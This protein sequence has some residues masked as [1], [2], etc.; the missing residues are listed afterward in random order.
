MPIKKNK[1]KTVEPFNI[2]Y[3][4]DCFIN[5]LLC[6]AKYYLLDFLILA[7][8]CYAFYDI[9]GNQLVSKKVKVFSIEELSNIIGLK[10]CR[11]RDYLIQWKQEYKSDFECGNLIIAP[12][13]DYY[14]PLRIDAYNKIHA[15][16]YTLLYDMNDKDSTLSVI[17]SKYRM[18]VFYKNMKMRYEDYEKSHFQKGM[19]YRYV[20]SKDMHNLKVQYKEKYKER[21]LHIIQFLT[22]QSISNLDYYICN[23]CQNASI[24][25]A[26]WI[27]NLNNICNQSKV[28][29]YIFDNIIGNESL[30]TISIEIL[31][32]WYLVR[33]NVVKLQMLEQSPLTKAKII[34]EL[35]IIEELEKKKKAQICICISTI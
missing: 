30:A 5:A 24:D 28:E 31:N 12:H 17:E 14:N 18:T 34:D 6:A 32:S 33:R 20:L 8:H 27:E 10:I 23:L 13:D 19:M 29:C 35:R 25:I 16:H 26:E 2:A 9:E 7:L 4:H 11:K 22:D 3:T 1:N 15:P 21:Y